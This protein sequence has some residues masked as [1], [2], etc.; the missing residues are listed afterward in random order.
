MNRRIRL[1]R[2]APRDQKQWNKAF[3][4]HKEQR[5]RR[6]LL[7]LKAIWDGQTLAEVCRTQHVGRKSLER[8]LDR[9]LHGGFAALLAPERRA[10]PQALSPARRK[11]LKYIVRHKTPAD[12][13][14]DSYQWTARRAQ[15]VIEQTWGIHL[16]LGRLYQLFH[17]FG[18]SHQKVH[19]DYGPAPPA[20]RAAVVAALKKTADLPADGVLVALDEFAL[21]SVPCTGYAWAPKHTAPKVQSDERRRQRLNGFLSVDLGSGTTHA[22]FRTESKTADVVFVVVLTLLRYIQAGFRSITLLLDNARTHRQEMKTAVLALLAEIATL[23]GWTAVQRTTVEFLPTPPYSPAFNPAEYL[24]HG[25]RQEALY[26]LPCTFTLEDKAD[27]VRQ[28][29]AQGPPLTPAKM[30]KLMHHIYRLPHHQSSQK[31]PQLE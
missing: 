17:Q 26:H 29:L 15:S 19:R 5:L 20:S 3:Y 11:V 4:R 25:V 31:R 9:Y 16:G 23:S 18:L 10:V 6:R 12:Y 22:D 14:I 1:Q 27:R 2:L 21:R 13:G 30:D 24:I 28:H 8:W 7:A